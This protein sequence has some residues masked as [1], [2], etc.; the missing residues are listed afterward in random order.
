MHVLIPSVFPLTL[1]DHQ[2]RVKLEKGKER[3]KIRT[4]SKEERECRHDKK[5]K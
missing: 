3:E 2:S 4:L 1:I 5:E